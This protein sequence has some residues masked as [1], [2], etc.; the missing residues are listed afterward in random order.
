[1]QIKDFIKTT[2]Q[3]GGPKIFIARNDKELLRYT[4]EITLGGYNFAK[5]RSDLFELSKKNNKIALT[6]TRDNINELMPVIATFSEGGMQIWN[7]DNTEHRWVENTDLSLALLCTDEIY[8][9]A[10]DLGYPLTTLSAL[11]YFS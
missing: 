11:K 7:S 6:L 4:L 3:I 9:K 10:Q 1:M 5:H 2:V 8:K